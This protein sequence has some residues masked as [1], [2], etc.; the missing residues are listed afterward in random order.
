MTKKSEDCRIQVGD[1]VF[2]VKREW[3]SQDDFAY[4]CKNISGFSHIV[5]VANIRTEF[6]PPCVTNFIGV[7]P[8]T[9]WTADV[10]SIHGDKE[11]FIVAVDY[12][13]VFEVLCLSN[14]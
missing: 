12:D 11:A 13:E 14:G 6:N 4:Q 9:V 3:L 8:D 7:R 10:I 1:I 5:H 2:L